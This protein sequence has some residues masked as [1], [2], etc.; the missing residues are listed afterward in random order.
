TAA[1]GGK[2]DKDTLKLTCLPSTV[3]P[4]FAN[5]VQP[6]FTAKCAYAGGCH[7]SGFRAGA[8]GSRPGQVLE[9]GVAYGDTVNVQ[10]SESPKF[11]RVKP[12]SIKSSFMARKILG[13]G[14]VPQPIGGARMPLGC[15]GGP[16]PSGGCLDQDELFTLLYWIAN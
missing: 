13:Q 14:I 7:D 5:A 4:S 9:P 6:I 16:L 3:A 10:S 1:S 2:R 8:N 11:L 15:P 12:G